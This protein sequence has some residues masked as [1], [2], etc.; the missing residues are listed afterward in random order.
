MLIVKVDYYRDVS[1]ISVNRRYLFI[2]ISLSFQIQKQIL[3][4]AVRSRLLRPWLSWQSAKD[5][6]GSFLSPDRQC[7]GLFQATHFSSLLLVA[8]SLLRS[9]TCQVPH[10]H[11]KETQISILAP[12]NL[13]VCPSYTTYLRCMKNVRHLY[14]SNQC[15]EAARIIYEMSDDQCRIISTLFLGLILMN[16][17]DLAKNCMFE[18]SLSGSF[19]ELL[20]GP[21]YIDNCKRTS[22]NGTTCLGHKSEALTTSR[23]LISP[24]QLRCCSSFVLSSFLHFFCLVTSFSYS[25]FC[26]HFLLSALLL[27]YPFHSSSLSHCIQIYF[28]LPCFLG[29]CV[30]M[31]LC[32]QSWDFYVSF[33][34]SIAP[35]LR[36]G[37]NCQSQCTVSYS[38]ASVCVCERERKKQ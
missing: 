37:T 3:M 34:L 19:Q 5:Y 29:V 7:G 18:G 33:S 31:R 24:H 10:R 16:N 8:S 11:K 36:P 1:I 17:E 28:H 21:S 25:P 30:R 13:Y 12:N 9:H 32:K 4:R 22:E 20:A 6:F 27:S 35:S 14:K 26:S 23:S 2:L 38:C 15:K